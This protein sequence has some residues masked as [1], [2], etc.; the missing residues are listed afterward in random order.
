MDITEW[1]GSEVLRLAQGDPERARRLLLTGYRTNLATLR[2]PFP[3]KGVSGA[4]RLAAITVMELIIKALAHPDGAAMVSLFTPCEPLFAAGIA[5][6]SLEAISGYLMGSKCEAGFQERSAEDGVPETMCSF[7]RTFLGAADAGLMPKPRFIIYTSLACDGNMITFPYLEKKFGV[8]GFFIDVPYDKSE[9]AVADVARQLRSMKDFVE[10]VSSR[11][12]TDGALRAAVRRSR[13]SAESYRRRLDSVASRQLK[14][15]VTGEMYCAF[16]SHILLGSKD[17]EKY[18]RLLEDETAKAPVSQAKRLLW[19]H[20]IPYLQPSL[21]RIM[22]F[23]D[24]AF[25]TACDLC[26][27]SLMTPMDERD[28]YASMARRLV[29]SGYNGDPG[30]RIENALKIARATR[31]DGAVI[32]AHW[33]CKATLGASRLMKDAFEEAGLPTLVLDGDACAPAN[34]GD[35]QLAT[36]V[37][38]FLEMLEAGK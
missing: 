5:P 28:P 24:R 6:Y 23:S 15:D 22:N 10:D 30:G 18:F 12:V 17:A 33:G 32:F 26:Y 1:F 34:T 36:R 11:R 3:S 8:P 20:T 14:G 7:H 29:Y 9:D 16:M 25:V 21:R 19:I 38:A 13:L 35:G 31:S 2:P 27:D 37:E 4:E